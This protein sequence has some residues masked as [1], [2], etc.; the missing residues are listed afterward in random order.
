MITG[1]GRRSAPL[2][3]LLHLGRVPAGVVH[4]RVACFICDVCLAR[5]L[6]LMATRGTAHSQLLYL[7]GL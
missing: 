1:T 7:C 5:V 2:R 4:L 3:R 6:H